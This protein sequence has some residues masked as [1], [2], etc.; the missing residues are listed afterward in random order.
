MSERRN[1]NDSAILAA[2]ASDQRRVLLRQLVQT[3]GSTS[4]AEMANRLSNADQ[5]ADDD[6]TRIR[7]ELHHVH[8]PKLD[9]A[10]IIEYD[11][12]RRLIEPGSEL[13]SAQA[14][15]RHVA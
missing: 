6:R 12:D 1:Q 2:L 9:A 7:A 8:L 11:A 15:L 10:D 3:S 4:V 5:R 14:I 13:E